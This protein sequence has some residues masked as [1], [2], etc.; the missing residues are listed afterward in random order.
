[1]SEEYR[2]WQEFCYRTVDDLKLPQDT[3]I[4]SPETLAGALAEVWMA[5]ALG[6]FHERLETLTDARLGPGH[7]PYIIIDSTA[8]DARLGPAPDEQRTAV[9][10]PPELWTVQP[11]GNLAMPALDTH[12]GRLAFLAAEDL[13]RVHALWEAVGPEDRKNLEHPLAALIKGWLLRPRAVQASNNHIF[14]FFMV[15]KDRDKTSRYPLAAHFGRREGRQMVL[16]GFESER[17][18]G[19]YLPEELYRLAEKEGARRGVVSLAQRA[20]IYAMLRTPSERAASPTGYWFRVPGKEYIALTHQ[21]NRRALRPAE[22]LPAL[23]GTRDILNTFDLP[24][25]DPDGKPRFFTP[26]AIMDYPLDPQDE[27]GFVTRLPPGYGGTGVQVSPRLWEFTNRTHVFYLMLSAPFLFDQPGITWRPRKGGGVSHFRDVEAYPVVTR[28]MIA[29]MANPFAADRTRRELMQ[30]A[31]NLVE[32]VARLT[33]AFQVA[34]REDA[35]IILPPGDV[36]NVDKSAKAK[37]F[38]IVRYEG[39]AG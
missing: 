33:G 7:T 38:A 15:Q 36:V 17:E 39:R 28:S 26:V 6:S 34:K 14:P 23:R 12:T 2:E 24:Y 30:N 1:M 20:L 9:R 16:P 13:A 5:D 3:Q 27:I 35:R 21:T 31:F 18:A 8:T 25:C 19:I 37:G 29:N 11:D 10:I 32:E 22:W 4:P